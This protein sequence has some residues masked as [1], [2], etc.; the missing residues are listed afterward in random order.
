MLPALLAS[1]QAQLLALAEAWLATGATTFSIWENEHLLAHWPDTSQPTETDLAASIQIGDKTLG[2]LRVTGLNDARAQARLEA[3]AGVLGQLAKL[4]NELESMTAELVDKQDQV[5]ALY[6]LTRSTRT[7]LDVEETLRLL[8]REAKRLVKADKAFIMLG[9]ASQPMLVEQCSTPIMDETTL[10]HLF[11]QVQISGEE[12][13][14]STNDLP[15]I[16]PTG[17]DNLFLK[18]I[19]I[20]NETTAL[21]GLLLNQ[22]AAALSPRL[23][24]A[25]AIAE[26]AGAQI[27]NALLYK[28]TLTQARLKTELELAARIQL[29]L[30]PQDPPKIDGLD[31]A[32][33]SRPAM[34][35]GGDFYDFV[36]QPGWP[37]TFTVGDVSGKGMSAALIM[38][39]TR[40]VIR[41]KA[42]FLPT[43]TPEIV[44]G[45][46]NEDMYHDF[47]EVGMFA[48]VFVG[49]Y[50]P[51]C[52]EL[53]YANAGHSP[54]IYCPVDGWARLLE[55]D[56]PAMGVLPLSLSENQTLIFDPGDVLVVATDGFCDASNSTGETFGY[57]RL[58]RLVETVAQNSASDIAE[59]VFDAVNNFSGS[60]PQ[61][62]DQTLVVVKGLE[63]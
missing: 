24:L 49:R 40:S 59:A 39:M 56:G 1:Q 52:R 37:F 36:S 44:L 31:L 63:A 34:H 27:E 18:R 21:L 38:A 22:P 48:T 62:D 58:L 8:T 23:K 61:N 42:K 45:H 32:A 3:E 28:E 9:T 14:L 33:G 16:V 43:P 41:S 47:T 17:T 30:L 54:V 50:D 46:S 15:S 12:L 26:Y 4:E 5:L 35:V 57:T 29:Q 10:Q 53:L 19:V 11:Q 13:L 55:A 6:D 51:T 60:H 20:R 7:H 2:E 25:R